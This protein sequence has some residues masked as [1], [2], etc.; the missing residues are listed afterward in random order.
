[1]IC[2]AANNRKLLTRNP[3]KL[4]NVQSCSI[5]LQIY[6]YACQHVQI[7]ATVLRELILHQTGVPTIIHNNIE[8][9][10]TYPPFRKHPT[11]C[12]LDDS[13]RNSLLKLIESFHFH[14]TRSSW[15]PSVEFL[16]PLLS[17]YSNLISIHLFDA[18]I[19]YAVNMYRTK[20]EAIYS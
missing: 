3:R 2:R 4:R 9:E 1:M 18:I 19:Q 12:M 15:V 14:A 11:D 8:L 6:K 13:F 20:I 5:L 16:C 10:E 17:R 7:E